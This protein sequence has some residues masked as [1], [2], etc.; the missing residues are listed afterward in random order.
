MLINDIR[1]ADR[2]IHSD[3]SL[4]LPTLFIS[5]QAPIKS[6]FGRGNDENLRGGLLSQFSELTSNRLSEGWRKRNT[7]LYDCK[8][9]WL[10]AYIYVYIYNSRCDHSEVIDLHATSALLCPEIERRKSCSLV[11][12]QAKLLLNKRAI[13]ITQ[14][15]KFMMNRFF[16]FYL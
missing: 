12:F 10:V 7:Y 13:E 14:N 1:E 15:L 16:L 5:S 8:L 6:M 2:D 3:S 9:P 11:C 4:W